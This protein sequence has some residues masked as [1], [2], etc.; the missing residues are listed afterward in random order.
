MSHDSRAHASREADETMAQRVGLNLVVC[1][2][3]LV[4]IH[5]DIAWV[6]CFRVFELLQTQRGPQKSQIQNATILGFRKYFELEVFS[7]GQKH[8]RT[9]RFRNTGNFACFEHGSP[10]RQSSQVRSWRSRQ[11]TPRTVRVLSA[12]LVGFV[13]RR[14]EGEGCKTDV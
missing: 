4:M 8:A 7:A 6:G 3:G 11:K 9:D 2:L 1:G 13:F 5:V 10:T 14:G 12:D